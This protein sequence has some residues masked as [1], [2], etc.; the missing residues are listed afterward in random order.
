MKTA[1]FTSI[2]ERQRIPSRRFA[3][4]AHDDIAMLAQ[5]D[6]RAD[7]LRRARTPHCAGDPRADHAMVVAAVI[8]IGDEP[9]FLAVPA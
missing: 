5:L 9:A 4:H 2:L 7:D 3:Q 6:G 8:Q 1:R